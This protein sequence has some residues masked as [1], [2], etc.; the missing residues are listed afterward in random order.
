MLVMLDAGSLLTSI[1]AQQPEASRCGGGHGER[2]V[3][4]PP[5]RGQIYFD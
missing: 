2:K 3:R 1:I 4:V 5:L